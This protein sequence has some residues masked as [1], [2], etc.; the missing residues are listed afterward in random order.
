[1]KKNVLYALLLITLSIV[2]VSAA[3][4]HD[5]LTDSGIE[6]NKDDNDNSIADTHNETKDNNVFSSDCNVLSVVGSSYSIILPKTITADQN[7]NSIDYYVDVDGDLAGDV[8]VSVIPDEE[9]VLHQAGRKDM[10][11]KIT[12]QIVKFYSKETTKKID[13]SIGKYIN[14]DEDDVINKNTESQ[15]NI[16]IEKIKAGT[17]EG[18]F[19]FH[20]KLESLE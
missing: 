11:A 13:E 17:W 4:S 20:I 8:C 19:T 1:M 9:V 12:Q 15:G 14:I 18:V 3:D 7:S 10:T 6:Y 2:S 5:Y 16:Y